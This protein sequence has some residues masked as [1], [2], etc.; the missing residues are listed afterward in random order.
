MPLTFFYKCI[1]RYFRE[2]KGYHNVLLHYNK[3]WGLNINTKKTES[4][5]TELENEEKLEIENEEIKKVNK[6]K[7]LGKKY[8]RLGKATVK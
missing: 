1:P 2:S 7:Y 6:L 8:N 3:K 5:S 4:L